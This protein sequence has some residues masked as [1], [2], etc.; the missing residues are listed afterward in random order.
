MLA[1]NRGIKIKEV[2]SRFPARD[3]S[4]GAPFQL[5]EQYAK[6]SFT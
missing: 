2:C 4:V 6:A 3:A 5:Q 1:A